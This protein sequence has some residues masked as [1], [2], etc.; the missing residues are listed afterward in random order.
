MTRFFWLLLGFVCAL[1][2]AHAAQAESVFSAGYTINLIDA[3]DQ[4]EVQTVAQFPKNEPIE[5]QFGKYSFSMTIR[6][7]SEEDFT[8]L[9]GVEREAIGLGSPQNLLTHE[10]TGTFDSIL[11]FEASNEF[12]EA[13]GAISVG[14]IER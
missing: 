10:F 11:E 4:W 8:L 14:V 7:I 2:A 6:E 13:K 1:I 12:L 3:D 9:L 5:H